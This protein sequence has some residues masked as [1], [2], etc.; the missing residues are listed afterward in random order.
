MWDNMKRTVF[1]ISDGTGITAEAL[2]NA[3]LSQFEGMEFNRVLLP[4][5]DT[6]DKARSTLEKIHTAKNQ[7]GVRPIIFDTIVNKEIR[8]YIR[9]GD[10]FPIDI[11]ETFLSP[12]EQELGHSS[13]YSVGK[14][15]SIDEENRY[16][17]RIDAVHFAMDNDDGARTK[18]YDKADIILIGVSRCGKT[19]TCIYMALQ[20]GLCAANYPLTEE[21][22][23]DGM[24]GLP[25]FLEANKNKLFGLTIDAENLSNIRNER[26]ANSRYASLAQCEMEVD[27]VE[28]L[29]VRMN[30]PYINSTYFSI[31]EISA[32]ILDITGIERKN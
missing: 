15:H 3:L 23:R 25:K 4:Y 6:I 13:S 31:E 2:G 19:P 30:I 7:D 8:E 24:I 11:F 29:F 26:R 27:M 9:T 21:D 16:K 14:S 32:K 10:G 5:I 12:L 28:E 20:Y 18:N 17:G 1:F 22:M